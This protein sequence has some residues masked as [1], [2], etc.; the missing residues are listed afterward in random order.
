MIEHCGTVWGLRGRSYLYAIFTSNY[1]YIG[2][3]GNMPAA[4]WGSHLSTADSS[5]AEKLKNEL[6]LHHLPAYEGEFLYIGLYCE[7]ADREEVAKRRFARRA[8]EE[9]IHREFLLNANEFGAPKKLL[10]TATGISDRIILGF[11]VDS[12]AKYAFKKI[13][14]E[15][16]LRSSHGVLG[17]VS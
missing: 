11:D 1:A 9:A 8:I 4:R 12:F 6:N 14:D 17:A 10:S 2:E 15:F 5:F 3:T 7:I 13:V 16:R